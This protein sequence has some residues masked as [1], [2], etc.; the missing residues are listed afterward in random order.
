MNYDENEIKNSIM[1]NVKIPFFCNF[2]KKNEYKI[3]KEN[4]L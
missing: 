4:S 2:R 1:E 3:K